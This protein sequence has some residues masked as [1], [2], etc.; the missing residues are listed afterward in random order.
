[1]IINQ[2]HMS[3]DFLDIMIIELMNFVY[4][5]VSTNH[6]QVNGGQVDDITLTSIALNHNPKS[7]K[8]IQQTFKYSLSLI[9]AHHFRPNPVSRTWQFRTR[10]FQTVP[11]LLWK[12]Q[13]V[14]SLIMG[15]DA[16]RINTPS[17]MCTTILN[18]C[19]QYFPDHF[20]MRQRLSI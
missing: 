10:P 2:C 12:C 18:L 19:K 16:E 20:A 4:I 15:K 13:L 11:N 1:M 6:P 5:Y 3:Y 9:F 17:A 8:S 7:M 14:L